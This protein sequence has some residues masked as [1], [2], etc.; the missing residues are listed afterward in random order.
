ME[1]PRSNTTIRIATN[2]GSASQFTN[3]TFIEL[4]GRTNHEKGEIYLKLSL[5]A[6]KELASLLED[7]RLSPSEKATYNRVYNASMDRFEE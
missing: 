3:L 4:K 7:E 6:L 2:L 1:L 5:A